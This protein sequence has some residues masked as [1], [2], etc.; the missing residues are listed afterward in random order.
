[1]T[2]LSILF[3]HIVYSILTMLTIDFT[4]ANLFGVHRWI[5]KDNL[6]PSSV[7]DHNALSNQKRHE[8][9]FLDAKDKRQTVFLANTNDN[10]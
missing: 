8:L 3:L 2:S 4:V 9:Q 1:M 6:M 10:H 5:I 7:T